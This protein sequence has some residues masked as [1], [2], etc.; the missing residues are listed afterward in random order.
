VFAKILIANRGEIACRVARTAHR[1]GVRTVAVFSDADAGSAH[2]AA[3]DEAV[4]IGGS[5]AQES[6][7]RGDVILDAARRLGAQA[8]HPGYGFLSENA[9]FAAGCARAGIVFI[10]PSAE[11]IAAMGSKSAA[12]VLMEKAGVPLT[13]GYHGEHQEA[14]Y[15]L[16]EATRIGFPVLIKAVAGGGGKG[17][18]RVDCAQ[19]FAAALASC[20]R[21]AA[22]S[23][24]DDRV[25]VEKYLTHAR[26]IEVQVFGDNHGNA[27]YLFERDCSVQRRHQ[28]VIEEAPAPGMTPKRR[29]QMGEAA[30]AAARAV[31]YSGAGTVEFIVDGSAFYFMEMNTRLQ[32]EHPV[33]EFVTGLDLVE[34]QLRVASG[35]RLPRTQDELSIT[36]HAIEARI[37][38]ED[39]A[40][41]FMPSTGK[42]EHLVAPEE[43]A[44]VRVDTGVRAGDE[45]TP[46]YD[47]MIAKLIVHAETRAGAI[48]RMR[49]AL[50]QY[51]I[52]GVHTNV[53]FL[54]RLMTAPAFV[55]AALD[56]ALIERERE[57]LFAER[58]AAADALW[59]RAAAAFW[60][61]QRDER[62]PGYQSP[63]DDGRGWALGV[64]GARRWKLRE[65]GVER[66]LTV[67]PAAGRL[68]NAFVHGNEIHVF[69]QGEHRTFEW[70]DPYLP[71]AVHADAHGGLRATMPGRVLAVHVQA[72]D[73]VR[74]GAALVVLEAMKM[75]Q[76]ITAPSAG[77]IGRVLC[78]PG[79][80]VREGAELLT[81]ADS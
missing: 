46:F 16:K 63:W 79:E 50:A 19:D 35:E 59:E 61:A 11:A 54:G 68:S 65:G 29:R 60:L 10:G 72:G 4:H 22:A 55:D 26:H 37:Y 67:P 48:E 34:W 81:F 9:E 71:E 33:T 2:V 74:K 12:K 7:L 1:L 36:G 17:M 5:P 66:E 24:K 78:S 15:L 77:T 45:I 39:P 43:G 56:T 23:F 8:V 13:P 21:E 49:T 73:E 70:I 64:R 14:D 31:E 51:Q 57:H 44:S 6:Y 69:H 41:D 52:A 53:E 30:V 28:K 32:V 25:L 75:E 58:G 47:P 62:E 18:R 27:V 3:C 80:Q 42:L 76:T 20:R 38:A 40:R